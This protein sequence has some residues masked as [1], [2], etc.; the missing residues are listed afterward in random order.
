MTKTTI[1]F[2]ATPKRWVLVNRKTSRMGRAYKTRS[3]ARL[4]KTGNQFIYDLAK[5][6]AVR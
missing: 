3:T 1:N 4:H 2:N 6:V 5:N